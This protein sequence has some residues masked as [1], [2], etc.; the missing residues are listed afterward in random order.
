[1]SGK[2]L[3]STGGRGKPNWLTD[4]VH[5]TCFSLARP[6]PLLTLSVSGSTVCHVLL[7]RIDFSFIT[8]SRCH[9]KP[10]QSDASVSLH[11]A[12]NGRLSNMVQSSA[13]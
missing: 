10:G 9:N 2:L 13:S 3:E 1:M 12:P 6:W 5:L 11:G 7:P 8:V 4:F